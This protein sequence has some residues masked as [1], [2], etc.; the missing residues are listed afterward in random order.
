MQRRF[1]T[2]RHSAYP[3]V[4]ADGRCVGVV[5]RDDVLAGELTTATAGDA[6]VVTVAA[7]DSLL[8]ALEKM[9]DEHADHLPVVVEGRLVGVC[10]RT[11]LLHAP[12][13][14]PRP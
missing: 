4:D 6:D 2:G 9:V 5:T 8:V 12:R 3:V 1:E 13:P 10:T 7:G 14:S 11:D